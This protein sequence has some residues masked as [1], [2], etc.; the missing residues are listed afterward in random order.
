M[1]KLE[2]KLGTK[3]KEDSK[4]MRDNERETGQM[5]CWISFDD[6]VG[7]ECKWKEEVDA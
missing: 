7:R 3:G 6:V 1:M 4:G 2:S 5:N